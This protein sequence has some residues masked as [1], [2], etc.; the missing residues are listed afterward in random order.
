MLFVSLV[1]STTTSFRG[2]SRAM[3][4]LYS[5][6]NLSFK[7][8]S[9]FTGRLWV[10]RLG[11][12][13]L[14]RNK[15]IAND[16]VWIID[17]T[18]QLGSEKC[19]V[20]VGLRLATLPPI[21]HCLSHQDI[22]PIALLPVTQSNGQIVLQQLSECVSKT[23]VPR[24]IVADHGSDLRSGILQFCT[25]HPETSFIYDIKHKTAA[26]LKQ[27]LKDDPIWAA[28]V[29]LASQSKRK[30]QSTQRKVYKNSPQT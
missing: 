20:I 4:L 30:I 10:L 14:T 13:K 5:S 15:Q 16:W 11:Y 29:Q 25:L 6:L 17:H 1:L 28:F 9:W 18:V 26:L 22:E 27:L 7:V 8:P 19:L 23:G 2:A 21:G 24:L 12:Y 3:E